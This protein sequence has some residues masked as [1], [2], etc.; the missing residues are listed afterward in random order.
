MQEEARQATDEAAKHKSRADKFEI[1]KMELI[2]TIGT[3]ESRI[4]TQRDD[5]EKWKRIG[6]GIEDETTRLETIAKEMETLRTLIA[7]SD[8]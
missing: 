4:R 7:R 5:L 1:E 6:R 3:L 8:V 2:S